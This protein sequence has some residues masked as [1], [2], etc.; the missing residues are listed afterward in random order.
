MI[1]S[2]RTDLWLSNGAKIEHVYEWYFYRGHIIGV[3]GRGEPEGYFM[4]EERRRRMKRFDSEPEFQAYLATNDLIPK[5]W[6]RWYGWRWSVTWEDI[7][8]GLAF[9][10]PVTWLL[11]FVLP[12]V[13]CLA[14]MRENFNPKRINTQIV[15]AVGLCTAVMMMLGRFPQSI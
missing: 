15:L 14:I 1:D 7:A 10:G 6:T 2:G 3:V 11:I 13:F 4:V 8:M 9:G 12:V 5:Y